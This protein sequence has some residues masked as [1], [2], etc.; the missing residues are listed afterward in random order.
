M[1]AKKLGKI[2]ELKYDSTRAEEI[3]A[4]VEVAEN[5]APGTYLADL[6]NKKLVDW[7]VAQI[8]NDFPPDVMEHLAVDSRRGAEEA[9]KVSQL[10]AELAKTKKYWEQDAENLHGQ[11]DQLTQRNEEHSGRIQGLYRE[12]N[13]LSEVRDSMQELV[14]RQ[15]AEI[16]RLKAKLYDLMEAK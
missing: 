13:E 8:E 2:F 4:L 11:I 6:F 5:L 10:E 1:T 3:A 14:D 9:Q 12:V 16:V 7:A 15:A